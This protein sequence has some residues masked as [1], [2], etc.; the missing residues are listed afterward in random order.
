MSKIY[1]TDWVDNVL[2]HSRC[3]DKKKGFYDEEHFITRNYVERIWL[4]Q[5]HLCHYCDKLMQIKKRNAVDGCTIER[6]D[7]HFG[8]TIKNCVLA[9][10]HCNCRKSY[11]AMWKRI[12]KKK[13]KTMTKKTNNIINVS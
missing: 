12:R 1:N 11:G 4:F 3:F 5:K 6:L 7:N 10:H 13:T 8:H 9:C 2:H